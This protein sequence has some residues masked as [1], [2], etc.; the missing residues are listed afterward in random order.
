MSFDTKPINDNDQGTTY[1]IVEMFEVARHHKFE[2]Q[3]VC[4]DSLMGDDDKVAYSQPG[5]PMYP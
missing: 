2:V 1:I 3:I 4:S 5:V